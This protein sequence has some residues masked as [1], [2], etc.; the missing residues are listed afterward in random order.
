VKGTGFGR[1]WA[2]PLVIALGGLLSGLLV[3]LLAPEAEGH[4]TDAAIEA[5]HEKGG[6][7]RAR[8]PPIVIA[9]AITIGSVGSAGREVPTAKISVGF[10]SLL[11]DLL[12]LESNERRILLAAGIGAGIGAIFRAPLAGAVLAAE[13]LYLRELEIEALF[14][15]LIA[16]IIGYSLFGSWAGF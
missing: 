5:F 3:F 4:G 15:G 12:K 1:P 9:E 2:L 6:R 10:G 16:S 13:I 7:I 11:G 8:I 14:P